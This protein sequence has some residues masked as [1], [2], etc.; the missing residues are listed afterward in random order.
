MYSDI[1]STCTGNI[2]STCTGDITSTCTGNITST[3]RGNITS[4]YTGDITSTC[5]GDINSSCTGDIY[6]MRCMAHIWIKYYLYDRKQYVSFNKLD[7]LY[8]KV[9][10]GVPRRSI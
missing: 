6:G 5:T 10:C 8:E 1:T 4:T 7:L 3:C 2:T 9:Y